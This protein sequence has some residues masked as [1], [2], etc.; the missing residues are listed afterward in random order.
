MGFPSGTDHIESKVHFF[1][2]GGQHSCHHIVRRV[3]MSCTH[4]RKTL[5]FAYAQKKKSKA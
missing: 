2:R 4:F 1:L 3:S 5:H